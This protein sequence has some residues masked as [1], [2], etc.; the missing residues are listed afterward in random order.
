[1]GVCYVFST[2]FFLFFFVLRFSE[3]EQ[4]TMTKT[5]GKDNSDLK[6]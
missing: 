4:W 5:G 2:L 1:M 6:H 3:T